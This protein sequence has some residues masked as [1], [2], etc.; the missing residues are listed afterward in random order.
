MEAEGWRR[1]HLNAKLYRWRKT[2][3]S[4]DNAS[5]T[6]ARPLTQMNF[7]LGDPFW[8]QEQAVPEMRKPRGMFLEQ[9]V[10]EIILPGTT[11]PPEEPTGNPLPP[12]GSQKPKRP[13]PSGSRLIATALM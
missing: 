6:V 9:A 5:Q 3:E 4:S 8:F 13:R 10:P 12:S 2:W 11:T 1:K 7:V